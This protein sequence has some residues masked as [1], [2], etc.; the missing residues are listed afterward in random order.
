MLLDLLNL[1]NKKINFEKI[2][3]DNLYIANEEDI[4]YFKQTFENI[5]FDDSFFKMFKKDKV[6]EF[7]LEII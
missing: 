1:L 3:I 4:N 7:I 2:N 6:K 5:L